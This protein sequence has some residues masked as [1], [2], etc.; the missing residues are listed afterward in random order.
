[1]ALG[2]PSV[3]CVNKDYCLLAVE[4]PKNGV[5]P[6]GSKAYLK[7]ERS[8]YLSFNDYIILHTTW[9]QQV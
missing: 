9:L 1:M 4:A 5:Y 6:R 7:A 3:F 2:A 8:V